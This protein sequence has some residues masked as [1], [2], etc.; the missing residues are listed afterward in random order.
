MILQSEI[1]E[2]TKVTVDTSVLDG[3]R[4]S[5]TSKIDP[6]AFKRVYVEEITTEGLNTA[7]AI[8]LGM[9]HSKNKSKTVSEMLQFN[10]KP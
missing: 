4:I 10:R 6:E 8:Y 1:L 3:N 5:L 2:L 9:L 7:K